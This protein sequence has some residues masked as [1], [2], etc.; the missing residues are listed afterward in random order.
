MRL[1]CK[2]NSYDS[3][4]SFFENHM[5][6][7]SLLCVTDIMRPLMYDRILTYNKRKDYTALIHA[8]SKKICHRRSLSEIGQYVMY[9]RLVNHYPRLGLKDGA[10]EAFR[11]TLPLNEDGEILIEG[12]RYYFYQ[13]SHAAFI[14]L[15]KTIKIIERI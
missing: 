3:F 2:E 15:E 7:G 9:K 6:I 12:V 11:Q 8:I 14:D 5:F 10:F 13:I 1:C 4:D